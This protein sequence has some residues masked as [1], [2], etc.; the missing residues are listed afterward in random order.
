MSAQPPTSQRVTVDGFTRQPWAAI[1]VDQIM[2]S[3]VL[4]CTRDTS[5]RD[6]ARMMVTHAIHAV[7]VVERD[8]RDDEFVTGVVTDSALALAAAEGRDATAE[9]LA[10]PRPPTVSAGW[11]LERAAR[12]MLRT[13]SSHV[14]VIDGRGAPIG[15]LSTLDLA[16]IV[17]WGHA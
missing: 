13:G 14:V 7:V 1:P 2:R 12:D 5:M 15:M 4:T 6:V 11:S 3:R 10:D 16:R 8:D 17:A 9:E